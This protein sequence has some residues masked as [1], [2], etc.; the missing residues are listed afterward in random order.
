M[1]LILHP[2]RPC[3]NH[4]WLRPLWVTKNLWEDQENIFLSKR[5]HHLPYSGFQVEIL[6]CRQVSAICHAMSKIRLWRRVGVQSE[7]THSTYKKF[8]RDNK[9]M[10]Y[11]YIF[12]HMGS[13][14]DFF[15]ALEETNLLKTSIMSKSRILLVRYDLWRELVRAENSPA[16]VSLPLPARGTPG[17]Q[18]FLFP[19]VAL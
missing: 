16:S 13:Q 2:W 1:N 18:A 19:F 3:G 12:P 10:E 7:L 17:P 15:A 5:E 9:F 4:W 8:S 14:L 6:K 11:I